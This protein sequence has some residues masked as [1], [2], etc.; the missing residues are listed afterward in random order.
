MGYRYDDHD[1]ALIGQ[2]SRQW[3]L[4]LTAY[5]RTQIERRIAT[6]LEREGFAGPAAFVQAVQQDPE[7]YRRFHSYLTIHV[8]EFFRD[9]E[10]W[11]RF[12]QA[13]KSQGGEYWRIWSAGCSWG[14][15]AVSVA[16]LMEDLKLHYEILA[17][18]SDELVLEKARRGEFPPADVDKIPQPYRSYLNATGHHWTVKSSGSNAIRF[19]RHNLLTDPLPGEFDAILCRNLL[20]YFEREIRLQ[21]LSRLSEALKNGGLLFLGATETFLEFA[22]YGFQVVAPSLYQK[23]SASGRKSSRNS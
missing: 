2:L 8:T 22:D 4:D 10:Y 9:P 18:D 1:W 16:L 7:V 14:A 3:G 19:E 21:A 15:E 5:K 20:I 12:R 13:V 6:F 11:E 17:T 23:V